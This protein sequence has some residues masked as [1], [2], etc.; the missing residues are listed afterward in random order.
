MGSLVHELQQAAMSD[1][2]SVGALL[3]KALV[4]SRKLGAVELVGWIE[5]E[6]NGYTRTSDLPEYRYLQGNLQCLHP[7]G[8][9]VPLSVNPRHAEL[10]QRRGMAQPLADLE[11]MGGPLEDSISRT[12]QLFYP[13]PFEGQ[14]MRE[15]GIP[16]PAFLVTAAAIHSI[17]NAVRN[18]VLDWALKLEEAGV[19]GQDMTF[20]QDEKSNAH[21]AEV[22]Y[23]IE[24][25][26]IFNQG[27]HSQIQ[28]GTVDST[29][30]LSHSGSGD[31]SALL[32]ATR[33]LQAKVDQLK[34]SPT[35]AAEVAA[36]LATIAAQATA[37]KPRLAFIRE[38]ARS[39]RTILEG[40]VGAAIG[41]DVALLVTQFKQAATE[42]FN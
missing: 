18:A 9:W 8:S 6:L 31:L 21:R 26:N 37:P 35:Q 24:N 10:L 5:R 32:A 40:A 2:H 36:D 25:Q 23:V 20:S 41:T 12:L 27:D 3:R 28:L 22:T 19:V 13:P 29:Q 14:L 17:P 33:E 38:S 34:L 42:L 30:S 39:V 1:A 16:R 11:A 4:T 7:S 15:L